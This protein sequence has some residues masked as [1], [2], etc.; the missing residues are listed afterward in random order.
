VITLDNIF[1]VCVR[2]SIFHFEEEEEEEKKKKK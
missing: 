1:S 2:N